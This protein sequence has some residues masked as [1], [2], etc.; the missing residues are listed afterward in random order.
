VAQGYLELARDTGD[1]ESLER[2]ASAHHRIEQLVDD[3]LQLARGGEPVTQPDRVPLG[4]L[5]EEAWGYVDTP[6]AD[7]AVEGPLPTV[8]GDRSRLIQLFENLFRNAVEHGGEDVTVSVGPLSDDRTGGGGADGDGTA[9]GV[10]VEDDGAGIPP[11]DREAVFDHGF[12]TGDQGTGYGLSIVADI[13]RAHGWSVTATDG[14]DGGARFEVAFE[15][16]DPTAD[17]GPS[18]SSVSEAPSSGE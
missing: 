6:A 17:A 1:T 2:V 16:A 18:P 12:S 14:R 3:L 11:A 4:E 7:L 8:A 5:V 15:P 13:V 10:F 9:D